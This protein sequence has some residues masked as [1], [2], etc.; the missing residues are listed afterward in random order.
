MSRLRRASLPKASNE[1]DLGYSSPERT[2]FLGVLE[3]AFKDAFPE[4]F[5]ALNQPYPAVIPTR[6][7]EDALEFLYSDYCLELVALADL[8]V[9]RFLNR[10]TEVAGVPYEVGRTITERYCFNLG[11]YFSAGRRRQGTCG[12]SLKQAAAAQTGTSTRS[13]CKAA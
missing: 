7:Q 4:V 11:V 6:I 9:N 2:L 10:L 5:Q 12:E 13:T 8:D 3:R 1:D